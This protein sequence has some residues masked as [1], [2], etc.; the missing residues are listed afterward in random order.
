MEGNS[1]ARLASRFLSDYG[2][3]VVLL[4]LCVVFSWLTWAEQYPGGANGG[5]GLALRVAREAA[6]GS[7]VLVVTRAS[8]EDRQFAAALAEGLEKAG[9][10]VLET[11]SGEPADARMALDR[12]AASA[13]RPDVIAGTSATGQWA[14]LG[15]LADKYPALAAARVITPESVW[16]PTFLMVENVRNVALQISIIAVIAIGMTMVIITG[17]IDLSVGSLIALAAVVAARLIRDE[18]GAEG[19]GAVGLILCSLAGIAACALVGLFSGVMVTTFAIPPFIVTLA[20]MLEGRGWASKLSAGQTISQV[21]DSYLWLGSGS[22]LLGI[23]NSV[24]LMVVL[25][26]AAHILMSR[27]TLGRYIYAVGGNAEAARLSGVPVKRV[28]LLV[29]TVCGALAG[30]GG[31]VMA[32]QLKGGS[33]NYGN[34]YELYVIAAVVVGGTSLNGGQGKIFGTLIGAF[35]IGVINNGMNL[36]GVDPYTQ[37]VVL[38]NVILGAVLLDVARRRGLSFLRRGRA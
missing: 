9:L 23:P 36:T 8:G 22:S 6:P 17:G 37:L 24:T 10:K 20:M 19:A 5:A 14:V 34:M 31:I 35:I 11:V 18:A 21:P 38:G 15:N 33:L 16:W 27:T 30:L 29:Y 28:L 3:I 13:D 26:V 12:L 4:V 7:R 25:Y 32:S 1:L 2:M